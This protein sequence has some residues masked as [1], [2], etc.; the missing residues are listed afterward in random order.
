MFHIDKIFFQTFHHVT[1]WKLI[2]FSMFH[3]KKGVKI[4]VML[5]KYI[6]FQE[7]SGVITEMITIENDTRKSYPTKHRDNRLNLYPPN[8]FQ[9]SLHFIMKEKY[10][11]HM[12]I[13]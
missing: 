6:P 7:E 2:V 3:I 8:L 12:V 11:K 13:Y 5:E 4:D 1:R 9:Q 10:Q